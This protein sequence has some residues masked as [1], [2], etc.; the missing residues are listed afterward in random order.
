MTYS[1]KP[2]K[3]RLPIFNLSI[4]GFWHN[5]IGLKWRQLGALRTSRS[6]GKPWT[7]HTK[8]L[9]QR[10]RWV[11]RPTKPPERPYSWSASKVDLPWELSIWSRDHSLS[12]DCHSSRGVPP[13]GDL[14]GC[15]TPKIPQ[16]YWILLWITDS[17]MVA[18]KNLGHT[19][20]PQHLMCQAWR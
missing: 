2:F 15:S 20:R 3:I 19:Q 10:P 11:L 6:L 1:D 5:Q 13:A 7:C 14:G 9:K 8:K 17:N 18:S 12:K 4:L 16:G